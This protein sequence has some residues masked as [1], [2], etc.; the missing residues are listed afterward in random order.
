MG[1]TELC[2]GFWS[3]WERRKVDAKRL[4]RSLVSSDGSGVKRRGY[5]IIKVVIMNNSRRH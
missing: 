2:K 4:W 1:M 3:E 5:L